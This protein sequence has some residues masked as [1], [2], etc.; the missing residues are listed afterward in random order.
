MK[1]KK[2]MSI[3]IVLL[4]I[5]S[6][7]LSGVAL[8]TFYAQKDKLQA[9]IY[10]INFLDETYAKEEI[11]NFYLQ[12]IFDNAINGLSTGWTQEQL[13]ENFSEELNKYKI[14]GEFIMPEL[15]QLESQLNSE[16]LYIENGKIVAKFGIDLENQA[17]QNKEIL[18]S[19][20]YHFE[21]KFEREIEKI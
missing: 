19:V 11:I 17:V 12:N 14:N 10:T 1:N 8:F 9:K 5:A 16:N 20:K 6:L 3:S 4:V 21:K 15:S 7:V 2:S 13:I 18:F